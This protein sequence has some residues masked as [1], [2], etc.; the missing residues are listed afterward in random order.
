MHRY[1]EGTDF[2]WESCRRHATIWPF[3]GRLPS[4][5]PEPPRH[6]LP[7]FLNHCPEM[8]VGEVW[9]APTF[10]QV[11][12]GR[13]QDDVSVEDLITQPVSIEQSIDIPLE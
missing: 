1:V 5:F 6:I 4:H 11:R 9:A 10:I 8:C 13:E 7:A 3:C 2:G 12:T